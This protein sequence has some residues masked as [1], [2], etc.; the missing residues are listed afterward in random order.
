M[1]A[2]NVP[3]P[4]D[5]RVEISGGGDARIDRSRLVLAGKAGVEPLRTPA[6]GSGVRGRRMGQECWLRHDGWR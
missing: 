5:V 2:P 6:G 1:Y 4:L 3:D